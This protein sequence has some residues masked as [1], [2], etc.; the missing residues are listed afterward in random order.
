MKKWIWTFLAFLTCLALP[1]AGG[2]TTAQAKEIEVELVGKLGGMSNFIEKESLGD[3]E[4]SIAGGLGLTA[5]NFNWTMS[6][7]RLE[8]SKLT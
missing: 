7:Q 6:E 1:W 4:F 3:S 5:L 8:L 2:Q